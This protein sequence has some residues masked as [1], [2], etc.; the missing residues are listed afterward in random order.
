MNFTDRAIH[1]LVGMLITIF[2]VGWWGEWRVRQTEQLSFAR[3]E[4]RAAEHILVTDEALR[5]ALTNPV[6]RG[7]A[8]SQAFTNVMT[9]ARRDPSVVDGVTKPGARR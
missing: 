6:E 3:W 4:I 1:L 8:Y 5:L 7:L 2:A 9:R